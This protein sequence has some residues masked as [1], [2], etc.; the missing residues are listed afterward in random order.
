MTALLLMLERGTWWTT[1]VGTFL[2][3]DKGQPVQ[4]WSSA[5][6]FRGFLDIF[7]RCVRRPR[8]PGGLYELTNFGQRVID[9]LP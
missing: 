2:G 7:A 4:F 5:E 9:E 8:N 6:H 1:P 3:E